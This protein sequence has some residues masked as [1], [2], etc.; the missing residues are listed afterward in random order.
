ML[1]DEKG[2]CQT[3]ELLKQCK[4]A[5]ANPVVPIPK[6]SA[7]LDP[8]LKS[9]TILPSMVEWARKHKVIA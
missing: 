5:P 8:T 6:H 2:I 4:L 7:C 9:E 1:I 3:F